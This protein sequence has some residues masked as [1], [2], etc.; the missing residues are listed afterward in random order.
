MA[1]C[2]V[3]QAVCIGEIESQMTAMKC[4]TC[5]TVVFVCPDCEE[6]PECPFCGYSCKWIILGSTD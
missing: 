3:C 4:E 2:E 5:N 6:T 1:I